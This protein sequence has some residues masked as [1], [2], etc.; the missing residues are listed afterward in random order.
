MAEN[1]EEAKRTAEHWHLGQ[2]SAAYESGP[3]GAGSISSGDGDHGGVS[4]GAYQLSSQSGTLREYLNQ[5]PYGA[6]F[7]GLT[8]VTPAFDA[9]WRELARTDPGFAQ[10]QHVFVGRSHYTEQTAALQARGL[11]LSDRGMAVQDALWSTAVQCRGLTPGIF[12]NG[13]KEKFG[14]HYDL[15]SLSDKDIVGAVQD[16]KR[17]HVETLFRRSP[18]LHDSLRDRFADEKVALE[19]LADSDAVLRVHGVVVEHPAGAP[20]PEQAHRNAPIHHGAHSEV[21]Q[22]HDRSDGVRDLQTRLANLG[23]AGADGQPLHADRQFGAN[24]QAAVEAFQRDHHLHVDGV[25]GSQTLNALRQAQPTPAAAMDDP[26]HA[27]HGMF[28]QALRVV[29]DLDAQQGRTPD[30]RST[31]LAGA[32]AAQSRTEGMSRIDHVVLSDDASRAYAVQGDLNSPFKQYASVNVAEAVVQ[33]LDQSTH[34][35]SQAHQQHQQQMAT[36]A[37]ENPQQAPTGPTMGR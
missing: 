22:L 3:A 24:T 10:D 12:V 25:A 8:P 15:A 31:L 35:W 33:P 14:D 34:V 9:R 36:Q 5:S 37:L 29:H 32:L 7:H 1:L 2:T 4:Y 23:Y 26:G 6:Q 13:L 30:Q 18:Q 17:G 19:R 27:G 11:D 20:V 16:Y 21:F 28:T